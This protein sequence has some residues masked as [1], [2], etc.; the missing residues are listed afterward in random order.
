MLNGEYKLFL[1]EA[2]MFCTDPFNERLH[3]ANPF[4]EYVARPMAMISKVRK[5]R[6]GDGRYYAQQIRAEDWRKAA[7][8]WIDRREKKRL[9]K[10]EEAEIN[11]L[12]EEMNK[13]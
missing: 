6:A 3:Y 13:K 11:E 9:L 12:R 1:T 8:E 2:E 10:E 7:F 5:M 4:F